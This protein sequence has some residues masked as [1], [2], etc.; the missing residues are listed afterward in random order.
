[1]AGKLFVAPLVMAIGW[2]LATVSTA[3]VLTKL[4]AVNSSATTLDATLG[5][6]SGVAVVGGTLV[7][8]LMLFV[9][10]LILRTLKSTGLF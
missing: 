1:M 5:T 4:G 2:I 7:V 8:L 6:L 9:A 10:L 3:S